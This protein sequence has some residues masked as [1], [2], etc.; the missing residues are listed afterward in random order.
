MR[1]SQGFLQLLHRIIPLP[2]AKKRQA[3]QTCFRFSLS[4]GFLTRRSKR[5]GALP[6]RKIYLKNPIYSFDITV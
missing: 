4:R 6:I 1:I 2:P 3:K 5:A